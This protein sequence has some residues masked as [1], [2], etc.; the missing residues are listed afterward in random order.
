VG[1]TVKDREKV[2]SLHLTAHASRKYSI[3]INK[4][5]MKEKRV[6]S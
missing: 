4:K 2:L 1:Q 3:I 5:L 6:L